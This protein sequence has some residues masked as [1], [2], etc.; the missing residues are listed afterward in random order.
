MY[1]GYS[2]AYSNAFGVQTLC[3]TVDDRNEHEERNIEWI[4]SCRI[5]GLVKAKAL[6]E[7]VAGMEKIATQMKANKE[8]MYQQ[9]HQLKQR[10]DQL[11]HQI[12]V[13][14]IE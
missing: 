8:Q 1:Y 2:T 10:I 7:Q 9:I 5:R 14:M 4:F 3:T 12:T 6:H 13:S 11:I